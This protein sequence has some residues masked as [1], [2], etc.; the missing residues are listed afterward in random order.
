MAVPDDQLEESHDGFRRN[1]TREQRSRQLYHHIDP[2]FVN[3]RLCFNVIGPQAVAAFNAQ[4]QPGNDHL[5]RLA[6]DH[7][8]TSTV[9]TIL[10]ARNAPSL[11]DVL[12]EPRQG[13]VF[14]ST[15]EVLGNPD[16]Y[17]LER[18]R[19]RIRLRFTHHYRVFLEYDRKKVSSDTL[20]MEL[21][22]GNITSIAGGIRGVQGRSVIV[23]PII[24]GGPWLEHPLNNDVG[25]DPSHLMWMGHDFFELLPG[26]IDEFRRISDVGDDIEPNEWRMYMSQTSE[27]DVK[28]K[29]AKL[30][31]DEIQAD[32]GG[33][34]QDHFSAHVHLSGRQVTA[35]FVFKGP[36]KFREMTPAM[37]GKNG[38]QI[39]RMAKTPAK[40]L[41]LQHCHSVGT[42]V[43]ETLRR[44]AVVPHDPR[45]FCVIDG[46][47]TYRLLKAYSQL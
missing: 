22:E 6:N 42:A 2:G 37:L 8:L 1:T 39:Y 40:V 14:S 21:R 44:F 3:H 28:L 23:A 17:E 41:V 31:R 4:A 32:W 34:E 24:M 35:A 29:I 16:F 26:D 30:L 45:H 5:S 11:G 25:I 47:D 10:R 43:R 7:L 12:Q 9:L 36:A 15:E 19:N 46:R 38:D 27:R 18:P 13:I 20:R 33:E